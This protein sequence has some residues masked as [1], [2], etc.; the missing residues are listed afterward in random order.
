MSDLAGFA[1]GWI[2]GESFGEIFG[3]GRIGI[4]LEDTGDVGAGFIELAGV[5]GDVGEVHTDGAAAGGAIESVLPERDGAVEMAG[6]GFDDAEI[7]G[8][9]DQFWIGG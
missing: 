4:E 5:A 8:G 3:A 1:V 9:V 7:C 6:A 2:G